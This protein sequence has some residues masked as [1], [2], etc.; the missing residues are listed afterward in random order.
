V[1]QILVVE[2]EPDLVELL[3][4]N[5]KAEGHGTHTAIDGAEALL[6]ADEK[7]LDLVLLDIGLP[8]MNGLEVCR[9]LRQKKKTAHLPIIFLTA[10]AEEEEV[11][12]GLSLGADDYLSKPFSMPELIARMKAVLRRSNP[13]LVENVMHFEEIEMDLERHE[14]KRGK[15]IIHLG[16][17]EFK[18]LKCLLERPGILL[19]R[20]KLLEKV[21]P[22]KYVEDRNIDVQVGRLRR[23]SNHKG[24]NKKSR[25]HATGMKSI[26]RLSETGSAPP[27][28]HRL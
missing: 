26:M 27:P 21:W 11:L 24:T 16:P 17:I 15:R 18:L 9:L 5:L 1:A 22:G 2:D 20:E 23:T 8:K 4:Y 3:N 12:K 14:V 25:S 19:T 7:D 6:Q 28:F 10:R 13:N